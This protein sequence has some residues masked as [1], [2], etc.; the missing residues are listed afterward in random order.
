MSDF[1][2]NV[3]NGSSYDFNIDDIQN[4]DII[5]NNDGTYHIIFNNKSYNIRI[6]NENINNKKYELCIDGQ[7]FEI[8]IKDSLDQMLDKMGYS[9]KLKGGSGEI[10]SPMPGLVLKLDIEKGQHIKKG[11]TLLILEAMKMENLIKAEYDLTVKTV[12]IK[13]GDSVAKNQLLLT[14]E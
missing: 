13:T 4:L 12:D 9:D 7:E 2:V 14:T 8:E 11:E 1:K 10:K 3:N 6:L 5:K